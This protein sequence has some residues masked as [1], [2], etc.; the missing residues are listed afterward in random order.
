M[1]SQFIDEL[2]KYLQRIST[3]GAII[4]QLLLLSY[5]Y[6]FITIVCMAVYDKPMVIKLSHDEYFYN[7]PTKGRH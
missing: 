5:I 3:N 2:I 6:L 7:R 1:R 4:C